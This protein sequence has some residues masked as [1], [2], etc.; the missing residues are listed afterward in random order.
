MAKK[1][2]YII[3]LIL[4]IFILPSQAAFPIELSKDIIVMARHGSLE[5]T[6]ENTFAAFERAINIGVGG[7]EIDVRKTRDNKLVLMHD[8]TIDRTTDGRGYVSLLLYEEIKLYDA[9][10]WKGEKF[11]GERVPLLSDALQFAKEKNIKVLLNVKEHGIKR[12]VLSHIKE[13]DMMDQIYFGGT[14]RSYRDKETD[15]PGSKLVF[16]LPDEITGNMIDYT[17]E[18]H[19]HV[20]TSMIGSDNIFEMSKRMIKG[21]DVILTDYPGVAVDLLNYEVKN[22]LKNKDIVAKDRLGTGVGGNDAQVLTLI[23]IM[24]NE[25]PDKSRLA[26]LAISSQPKET[27]IP[28]LVELLTYKKK[29]RGF[30]PVGKIFSVFKKEEKEYSLPA[31]IVRR[32]AAWSLGLI[33]DNSAV[34]PLI[35]HLKTDDLELRREIVHALKR[36][37]DTQT[38]LL[39]ND[40][41]LNDEAPYVRYDAAGALGEIKD[42]D[43]VYPLITALKNDGKWI[44]KAGCAEAL[45]KIGNNKAVNTLKDILTTDA[46]S[47]SSWARDRA[48]WALSEI[49]NGAINA[50]VSALE[51]NEENTRRRACWAL[52]RIGKPAIPQLTTVLRSSDKLVRSRAAFALGWIRSKK[53]ILSLSW[54]L[55]D[56]ETD[57]RKMATWALGRIGG[58]QAADALK[59][60][61]ND[62]DESVVEYA[63]EAIQRIKL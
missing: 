41:L 55:R 28:I 9:G 5:D 36:I 44:V 27:I 13:F 4:T 58:A 54:A 57:V 20:G 34:Q 42:G 47:E 30:N 50:L 21:V 2:Y 37:A 53:A 6:P 61:L 16:L 24:T 32:N 60:L 8:D 17:H 3:P 38:T 12:L 51:D 62:Q 49:G 18:K 1:L 29:L 22:T 63:R 25:Q 43:S 56:N 39:L 35:K 52:T 59:G 26:A 19:N 40:I 48:A 46:G 14:L 11:T 45:G 7:L 31:K 10:T 33:G 15:I 23:D